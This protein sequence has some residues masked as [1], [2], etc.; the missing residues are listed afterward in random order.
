MDLH[1]A[2]YERHLWRAPNR[3]VVRG[4]FSEALVS[5]DLYEQRF[6]I[7]PVE[8]PARTILERLM[9]AAGLAAVSLA[10][11]ESWGWSVT[12]PGVAEGFFCGVEPEGMICGRVREAERSE[13]IAV[14]QRQKGDAPLFQSSFVPP[15]AEPVAAVAA[16]FDQVEQLPTRLAVRGRGPGVLVQALPG[17]ALDELIPLDDEQLLV[18]IDDADTAG[19][20]ERLDEVVLFYECRCND[21][22][23]AKMLDG[24]SEKQRSYLWESEDELTIECPR[25]G[26][27]YRA[28]RD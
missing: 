6:G 13:A 3:L 17:G 9:A 18:A 26:R 10:E 11:R 7:P 28:R 5:R 25:C 1:L 21:E 8:V 24:M 14:L 22:L 16:Y 4:D 12:L 2:R 23:I 15:S 27:E 20:L 19:E